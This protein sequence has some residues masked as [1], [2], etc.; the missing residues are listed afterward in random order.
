MRYFFSFIFLLLTTSCASDQEIDTYVLHLKISKNEE[1]TYKRIIKFDKSSSLYFV[2]DYFENGQIQMEGNY[3][4]F[5][6]EIKEEYQ[7]NYFLWSL[8]SQQNSVPPIHLPNRKLLL[9]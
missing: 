9:N 4:S 6:R 2:K 3:S 1:I 5:D 8:R 7:C